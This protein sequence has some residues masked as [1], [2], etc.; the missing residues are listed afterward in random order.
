MKFIYPAVFEKV[1]ENQYKGY[2]PDLEGCYASGETLLDAIEDASE[3]AYNWISVELE[4]PEAHLPAVTD[5]RDIVLK[6]N[7]TVHNI[8][9]TIRLMEGWEE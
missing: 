7:E 4:E 9:V 8:L 1:S 3:A 5:G 6:E 2:F